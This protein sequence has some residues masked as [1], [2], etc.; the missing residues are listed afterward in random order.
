MKET[1]HPSAARPG[2]EGRPTRA[3]LPAELL[4][5]RFTEGHL[6]LLQHQGPTDGPPGSGHVTPRPSGSRPSAPFWSGRGAQKGAGVPRPR[7]PA[8]G[9]RGRTLGRVRTPAPPSPGASGP[10]PARPGSVPGSVPG[11]GRSGRRAP[12]PRAPRLPGRRP[13]CAQR[14]TRGPRGRRAGRSRS[15][16]RLSGGRRACVIHQEFLFSPPRGW[17]KKQ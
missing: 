7:A 14:R 3:S 8:S 15:R 2:G 5:T 4:L 11:R 12:H 9:L 6:R 16:A 13:L 17:K 1:E 10:R